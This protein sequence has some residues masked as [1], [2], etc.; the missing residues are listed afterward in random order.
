M[1]RLFMLCLVCF[2]AASEAS[3]RDCSVE[4]AGF[5][6]RSLILSM[7][8]AVNC[9]NS[10][11]ASLKRRQAKLEKVVAGY[12]RLFGELPAP[13]LNDN[14]EITSEPGRKIG[15]A[16]Y[17]LDARRTGGA[18]FVPI[19]QTVLEELCADRGCQLSLAIRVI[20]SFSKEPLESTIVGPCNFNYDSRTGAWLRGE[21]CSGGVLHG[22]DGNGTAGVGNGGAETIVEVG[23]GCL[24]TDAGVR[25]SVGTDP[26]IL[27]RDHALGL[28]LVAAPDLR[29]NGGRRFQCDLEIE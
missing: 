14:G 4:K 28:F 29:T 2:V 19:K 5:G 15:R 21:G 11:I 10:E 1:A 3:A 23:E 16:T 12:E 13:Y 8:K 27:E 25:R 26:N 7:V 17:I 9:L 20:G 6:D 24:V 22:R 18:S